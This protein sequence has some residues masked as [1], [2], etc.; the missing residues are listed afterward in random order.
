MTIWED[1]HATKGCVLPDEV[2]IRWEKAVSSFK[3][4]CSHVVPSSHLPLLLWT[5]WDK[6]HHWGQGAGSQIV[7][8]VHI[9]M[10]YLIFMI[11]Y[12]YDMM[13]HCRSSSFPTLCSGAVFLSSLYYPSCRWEN[14]FWEESFL[15]RNTSKVS[16]PRCCWEI[17][18]N[19]CRNQGA[20]GR[21]LRV[22]GLHK[23]VRA[24]WPQ[25]TV[26][27]PSRWLLNLKFSILS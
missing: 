13:P 23:S 15:L 12:I 4:G 22:H 11:W 24:D 19:K 14:T 8:G 5:L 3:G 16:K 9:F 7:I 6:N 25:E 18:L 2:V 17:R 20:C 27:F 1:I 10:I 26:R 21:F